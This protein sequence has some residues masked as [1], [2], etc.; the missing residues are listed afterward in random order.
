MSKP[1]N[2]VTVSK[3]SLIG[4]AAKRI[5]AL[6]ELLVCYR[7]GRRP[8]ERLLNKLE[9]TKKLWDDLTETP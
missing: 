1:N 3:K 4:I 8:T 7:I 9:K 6:E 2:A 5:R